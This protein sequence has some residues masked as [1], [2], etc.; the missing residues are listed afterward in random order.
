M[1]RRSCEDR[2]K[3]VIEP[4]APEAIFIIWGLCQANPRPWHARPDSDACNVRAGPLPVAIPIRYSECPI[5]IGLAG[6]AKV[7]WKGKAA[8]A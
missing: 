6:Q 3:P 2:M 1:V 8:R 5:G 7:D 4:G